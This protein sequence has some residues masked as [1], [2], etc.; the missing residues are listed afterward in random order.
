M[1]KLSNPI[2]QTYDISYLSSLFAVSGD[3]YEHHSE[4]S[5]LLSPGNQKQDKK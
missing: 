5:A 4:F 1:R 3:F 2:F